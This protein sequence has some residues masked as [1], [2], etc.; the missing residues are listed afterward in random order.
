MK[1]WIL[2]ALIIAG[3]LG[4]AYNS[5]QIIVKNTSNAF[6]AQQLFTVRETARGI[7]SL[8]DNLELSLRTSRGRLHD[9]LA[10]EKRLREAGFGQIQFAHLPAAPYYWGLVLGQKS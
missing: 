5:W 10:I 4:V 8:L 6:N 7:E 2:T 1:I 9:P 3:I